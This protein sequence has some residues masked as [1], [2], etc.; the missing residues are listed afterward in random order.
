MLPTRG[1]KSATKDITPKALTFQVAHSH[2]CH[3]V[4]VGHMDLSEV[5]H[6]CLK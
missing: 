6:G 1:V 5:G 4:E 3:M 2:L